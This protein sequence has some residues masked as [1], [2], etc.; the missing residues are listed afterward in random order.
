MDTENIEHFLFLR[1]K[2]LNILSYLTELIN[3]YEELYNHNNDV[4]SSIQYNK[5]K[6]D[7]I[8]VKSKIYDINYKIYIMCS[9]DFVQ[10]EIDINPDKTQR[11]EYCKK[12]E[13]TK[14]QD[15]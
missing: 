13:Y 9:H 11:I 1:K 8:D 14:K 3:L 10:D 2:Y 4:T 15:F 12:C 5:Y 7:F 6:I